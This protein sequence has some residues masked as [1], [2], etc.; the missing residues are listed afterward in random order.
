MYFLAQ[1]P[2]KAKV[3]TVEAGIESLAPPIIHEARKQG[4]RVYRQ[5]DVFAVESNLTDEQ[6]YE[7]AVTRVRRD[8]VLA[9]RVGT[10]WTREVQAAIQEGRKIVWPEPAE[11]EVREAHLCPCCGET[12][13]T[14]GSG[15]AAR[16]AL[17]IYR[18]GH[19]ATEVVVGKK[20]VTYIRGTMHHDP[21]IET[22]G[23]HREHIDVTLGDPNDPEDAK[24]Y[25]AVRN[26]VPRRRRRRTEESTNQE[27]G[28]S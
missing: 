5:G 20:G 19:T 25:V 16:A 3:E 6:V 17:S 11:G 21:G 4:R 13:M 14:D 1:L 26:T 8:V 15:A 12:T 7:G 22:P 10:L 18:T 23:R 9:A 2:D 28:D 24:W 27:G